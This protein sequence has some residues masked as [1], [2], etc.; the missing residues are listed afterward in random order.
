MKTKKV[1]VI[2]E[3][4]LYTVPRLSYFIS[5]YEITGTVYNIEIYGR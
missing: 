4:Q 3:L 1:I 2:R 5:E